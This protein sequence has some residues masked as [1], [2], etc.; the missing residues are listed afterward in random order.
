MMP[1]QAISVQLSDVEYDAHSR[2][3]VLWLDV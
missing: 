1:L 3:L 2:R